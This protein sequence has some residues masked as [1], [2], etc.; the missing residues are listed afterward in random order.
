MLTLTYTYEIYIYIV[1]VVL[2]AKS[3]RH[4]CD[5]MDYIAHSLLCP[6]DFPGKYTRVGYSFLL[7]GI[8]PTQVSNPCLLH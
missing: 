6:W 5:L 2:V 8:F 3:F 7:Q 1:V 4:F